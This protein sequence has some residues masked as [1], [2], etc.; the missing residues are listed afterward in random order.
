[1]CRYW[2]AI[3]HWNM[4][5]E[6]TPDWAELHEMKAQVSASNCADGWCRLAWFFLI[7]CSQGVSEC[8]LYSLMSFAVWMYTYIYLYTYI[9]M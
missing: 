1:M 9:L 7:I 3:R 6:L 8:G 2:D 5:L 4:A